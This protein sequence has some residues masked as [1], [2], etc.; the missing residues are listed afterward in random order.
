MHASWTW[1]SKDGPGPAGQRLRYEPGSWGDV[2]KGLVIA[3]L[4]PVLRAQHGQLRVADLFAGAP[5]YPCERA[6][7]ERLAMAAE[8]RFARTLTGDRFPSTAT[9]V[10]ASVPDAT[11]T[12]TDR[13]PERRALWF[14]QGVT[15][16][17]EDD[18]Y[19]ALESL[20]PSAFELVL[21]DPY[22]LAEP[23]RSATALPAVRR[24]AQRTTLLLYAY[25][26]STA[27]AFAHHVAFAHA[28]G[29]CGL[30]V[31]LPSDALLPRGWHEVRVLGPALPPLDA[32]VA[33]VRDVAARLLLPACATVL[34]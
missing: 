27:A 7:R 19:T 16:F 21:V 11:L 18:G 20:E 15:L 29:P 1:R 14:G 28:L 22:D 2:L 13:D 9:L 31:R 25:W 30:V 4:A 17:D 26:K 33:E 24:L 8:T 34:R 12:V 10:R 23:S 5:D 6:T 32:I 3:H